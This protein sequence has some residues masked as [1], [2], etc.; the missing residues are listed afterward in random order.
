MQSA[1]ANCYEQKE[2]EKKKNHTYNNM[3]SIS[4]QEHCIVVRFMTTTRSANNTAFL[5]KDS[6]NMSTR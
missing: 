2:T 1:K 6:N 5:T 3:S 4:L